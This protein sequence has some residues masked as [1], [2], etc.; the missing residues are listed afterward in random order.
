MKKTFWVLISLLPILGTTHFSR[1]TSKEVKA[2]L[3]VLQ[4]NPNNKKLLQLALELAKKAEVQRGKK[5]KAL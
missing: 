1:A 4:D 5:T 2:E 3:K